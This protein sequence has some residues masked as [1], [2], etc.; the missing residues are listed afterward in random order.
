MM[1]WRE[2]VVTMAIALLPAAVMRGGSRSEIPAPE[3]VQ[4]PVTFSGHVAP[5]VHERCAP[6]H[7]PE[8]DAPFS[9]VTYPEVRQRASQIAIVTAKRLMPPWKPEPGHGQ[10]LGDRRLSDGEIATIGQWVA[11][12]APE[13][14]PID[15]RPDPG[16]TAG[17]PLGLPDVMVRLPDYVLRADGADVFRNFVVTVPGEGT[18][19]VR[20]LLLRPGNRAV[21]HA[22]I[23]IDPTPASRRLDEADPVPGYEGIILRSADFPD[24]HFLG[25]TPGQVPQFGF[26]DSAWRLQLGTDLVVQLHMQP[27]GTAETVRASIGLYF[28][29]EPP[30]RTPVMIRLGRQTLEIPAGAARHRVGDAYT[31]P[32]DAEIHAIQPHAHVRARETRAWATL[33]GGEQRT[34]IWIADWDFRWQDV[35]RYRSP[36]WLPA[37]TR[38]EMEF[39]FDNSDANP[40]NPDRPPRRVE[41]GWR[42]ADEMGDVWIQAMTRSGAERA[43]LLSDVRNKMLTEDAKGCEVL[44]ARDPGHVS[45]RYDAALIYMTLRRPSR[46]LEHFEAAMRLEPQSAVGRY[47]VGVA[48]EAL[49]RAAE[50]DRIYREAL[51]LNPAYSAAH[52]NLGNL[53]LSTGRVDEARQHYVRAIESDTANAEARR[54]LGAVLV[55]SY[56]PEAALT[57][58]S[59]A[60][61]QRP[62]WPP[63]LVSIAWLRAAYRD[64]WVRR[65]AE[66]VSLAER[67]LTLMP[68]DL[69]TLDVLAVAY[70]SAGRFDDA[71]QTAEHAVV[72]GTQSGQTTLVRQILARLERFRH[73]Q[74]FVLP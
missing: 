67:A 74:P 31:L 25:W 19:F 45:L 23:R 58:F 17:W 65:P 32:V 48:L 50:A 20:G 73:R 64:A 39:V 27:T 2:R 38:I 61:R 46:A 53:L 59:E 12:G 35:Y 60:L 47:N 66:A 7:H 69:A 68:D 18:R 44:I 33:P 62:E 41:W 36:F 55:A 4:A 57:Q 11:A 30:V 37:G 71:V 40:R 8:G 10:F 16:A 6:C 49:G 29:A 54:N 72:V 3:S 52:N 14:A 56:E 1:H 24:G 51:A 26:R 43:S 70:A 15:R 21:H 13:G 22:N 9:L 34:L 42:S 28:T 63:L 5:I